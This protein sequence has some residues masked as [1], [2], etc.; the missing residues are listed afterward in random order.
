M[1]K[2]RC[3]R[4]SAVITASG[5]TVKCVR[6]G[7]QGAVDPPRPAPSTSTA[8]GT[9][10]KRPEAKGGDTKAGDGK[11]P[12][13]ITLDLRK[14]SPKN[15]G[16]RTKVF[17]VFVLLAGAFFLGGMAGV[18]FEQARTEITEDLDRGES[19]LGGNEANSSG[20][21]SAGAPGLGDAGDTGDGGD[22]GDGGP[23]GTEGNGSGDPDPD[24][25]PDSDPAPDNGSGPDPDNGTDP[26]NGPDAQPEGEPEPIRFDGFEDIVTDAFVT[27]EPLWR[28]WIEH[29]GQDLR[30]RI[31]DADSGE[32]VQTILITQPSPYWAARYVS[33]PPGE[34]YLDVDVTASGASSEWYIAIDQPRPADGTDA[35]SISWSGN[36]DGD[37]GTEADPRP[38]VLLD[39]AH[40]VEF[41]AWGAGQARLTVFALDGTEVCLLEDAAGQSGPADATKECSVAQDTLVFFDVRAPRDAEG[42]GWTLSVTDA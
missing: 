16:T 22:G 30:V 12:F 17:A 10:P 25:E 5:D 26:D 3:P 36:G 20:S 27:E 7:L 24:S 1:R 41:K 42:R 23:D 2:V 9:A 37:G 28:V 13:V 11:D 38:A 31:H 39:G 40:Q 34:Y 19:L 15:W 18:A 29:F 6:C 14:V 32:R 21:G 4:C 33:H 35:S 8:G